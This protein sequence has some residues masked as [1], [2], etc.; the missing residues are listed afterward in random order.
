MNLFLHN[1]AVVACSIA[2]G[3]YQTGEKSLQDTQAEKETLFR[4]AA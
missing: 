4:T 1:F 3:E 2:A